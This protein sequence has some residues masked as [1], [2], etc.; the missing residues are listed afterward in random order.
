LPQPHLKRF[1]QP[2]HQTLGRCGEYTRTVA[3]ARGLAAKTSTLES[4]ADNRLRTVVFQAGLNLNPAIGCEQQR[5]EDA[6]KKPGNGKFAGWFGFTCQVKASDFGEV[7]CIP[8]F[9]AFASSCLCCSTAEF[10]LKAGFCPALASSGP[11]CPGIALLLAGCLAARPLP[12]A[13]GLGDGAKPPENRQ[14]LP[15]AALHQL[16]QDGAAMNESEK[17]FSFTRAASSTS[18]RERKQIPA[19]SSALALDPT[20]Q[21]VNLKYVFRDR[22]FHERLTI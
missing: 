18:G 21:L 1:L 9:P 7:P 3:C 22:P 16:W 14:D 12:P 19:I 4:P 13:Y 5:R 2:F 17:Q 6:K 8:W 20:H 10:R 11:V 15:V